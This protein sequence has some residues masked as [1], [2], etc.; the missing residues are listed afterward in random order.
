MAS[1]PESRLEGKPR[2][3]TRP[4]PQAIAAD[5][6][7][8]GWAGLALRAG[9]KRPLEEWKELGFRDLA[10]LQVDWRPFRNCAVGVLTGVSH[11]VA[12][13]VDG[14]VGLRSWNRLYRGHPRLVTAWV[15]THRGFQIIFGVSG[16][17]YKTCAGLVAPGIDVRGW[18]G[19][20]KVA[21]P[22]EPERRLGG[23]EPDAVPAWLG[24]A[25]P[26]AGDRPEGTGTAGASRSPRTGLAALG[27]ALLA[28][29]V[30]QHDGL[31]DYTLEAQKRYGDSVAVPMA[32]ELSQLLP[33]LRPGDPWREAHIRAML[34]PGI[35]PDGS[36]HEIPTRDRV[37][38]LGRP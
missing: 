25:L 14:P 38:F 21:D 4:F 6:T 23:G 3:G 36:P 35:V 7:D 19:M 10:Q 9:T 24:A 16:E 28:G 12:V 15:K 22:S 29:E 33:E 2:R 31:R 18:G 26:L 37:T 32:F 8:R 1:V 20:I 11:I 13:D 5:I 27:R 30:S 17:R 34:K